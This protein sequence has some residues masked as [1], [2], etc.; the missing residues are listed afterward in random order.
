[1]IINNNL[2]ENNFSFL[3]SADGSSW[4]PSSRSRI[5]SQH[6]VGGKK[7]DHPH[8]PAYLPTIFPEQ[9]Y[10]KQKLTEAYQSNAQKRSNNYQYIFI[11]IYT[12]SFI[13]ILIIALKK[14]SYVLSTTGLQEQC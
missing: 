5:C 7:S 6:F 12:H 8:S 3:F 11:Y 14:A 9:Y 13:F 1:M 4:E 2:L 10:G